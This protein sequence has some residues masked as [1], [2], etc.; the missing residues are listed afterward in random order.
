MSKFAITEISTGNLG[1]ELMAEAYI[2]DT[3]MQPEVGGNQ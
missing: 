2:N 3:A 1:K